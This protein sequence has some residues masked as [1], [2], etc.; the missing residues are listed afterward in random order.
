M[1]KKFLKKNWKPVFPETIQL[2][3]KTTRMQCAYQ[4][5]PHGSLRTFCKIVVWGGT[6]RVC[7]LHGTACLEGT[8]SFGL[9]NVS[10][11]N[12]TY[13]ST[14]QDRCDAFRSCLGKIT[15]MQ[16]GAVWFG[17]PATAGRKQEIHRL[18]L[19]SSA[20]RGL[21][22]LIRDDRQAQTA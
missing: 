12:Q 1:T 9:K 21:I 5:D 10:V 18:S 22:N 19:K 17:W 14:H 7:P 4:F 2:P 13:S 20:L 11:S 3:S 16:K 15:C 8:A 6:W